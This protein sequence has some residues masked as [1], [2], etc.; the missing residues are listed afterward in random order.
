MIGVIPM[1]APR[2]H[3]VPGDSNDDMI[4]HTTTTAV[5]GRVLLGL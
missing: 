2:P 3:L 4:Q 5:R 1:I